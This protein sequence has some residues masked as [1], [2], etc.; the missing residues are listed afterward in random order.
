[1]TFIDVG[2]NMGLYTLFAARKV[3]PHGVVVAI[4]PSSREFA[5]LK[6]HIELNRLANVRLLQVAV[7]NCRGE[8]DLLV[9]TEEK[10]GHNTLGAFGYDSVTPQGNE[11][12]PV[13][14][15]DDIVQ[16]EEL[17]R[18]DVIKMDIEGAEFLALQGATRTLSQFRPVLLLEISD[19]TLAHQGCSSQQVWEFLTQIGYSIYSFDDRTGLPVPSQR[20]HY[21][22]S[23]NVIAIHRLSEGQ[24][25]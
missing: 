17:Q 18:V 25:P 3:G 9:A 4:E 19:R 21:F 20:K 10:S 24:W 8:A 12:V 2:A 7:S 5:R 14:R 11:R 22:D 16:Q 23:E 13:E 15:L 1:M 6:A